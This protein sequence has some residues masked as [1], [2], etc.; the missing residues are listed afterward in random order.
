MKNKGYY[1]YDNGI[2]PRK[3]WVHIGRDLNKLIETCF[4]GCEAPDADYGGVTYSNA[5]RKSD[6]KYGV[7]VSFPS[8]KDMTMKNCCHEA[9][10]VCDG[11]EEAMGMEHGDEASAYL[12]GWIASCIN[13]A[14]LGVGDF[15]ELKDKEK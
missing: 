11:I 1:E 5:V 8:T 6:S 10:H 15:I 12:I 4:D 9:S 2:Y 3:L 13:K 14:R 7:L